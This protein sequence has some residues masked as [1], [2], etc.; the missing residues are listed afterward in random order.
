MD[1]LNGVTPEEYWEIEG[2]KWPVTRVEGKLYCQTNLGWMPVYEISWAWP[3]LGG[4][5]L[6]GLVMAFS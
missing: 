3:I 5:A 6:V 4:L 2:R 1:D